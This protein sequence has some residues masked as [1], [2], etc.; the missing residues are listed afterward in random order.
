[1]KADDV[2]L[3]LNMNVRI[4]CLFECEMLCQVEIDNHG[5]EMFVSKVSNFEMERRFRTFEKDLKILLKYTSIQAN[6]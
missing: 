3:N 1:M 2:K 5:R 6:L 4:R